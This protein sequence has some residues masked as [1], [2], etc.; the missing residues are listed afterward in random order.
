[1][2]ENLQE[3]LKKTLFA[4]VGATVMSA[5]AV[6]SALTDLVNKGKLSAEDAK[7]AFDKA[8]ARGEEDAKA[9]YEKAKARGEEALESLTC[10]KRIEL[11]EQRVAALEAKLGCVPAEAPCAAPAQDVEN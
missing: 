4:G 6:K 9:F 2:L 5:D 7:A 11:L 10:A 3:T 8:A 1:M